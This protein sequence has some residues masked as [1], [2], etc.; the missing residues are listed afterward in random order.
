MPHY[1]HTEQV[2]AAPADIF[3]ILEDTDRTPEW[4]KRC[5]KIDRLEDG[6]TREGLPLRYHYQD[7]KRTGEMA[8]TVSAF[9]PG[10]HMTMSFTDKITDVSVDFVT[11]DGPTPG[12]TTLTHTIDIKTKG[13]GKMFTPMINKAL[14][15][16]TLSAMANLKALAES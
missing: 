5:T 12:T 2:N 4:L 11:A 9:E 8:G 13:I 14:P 10:R 6:P 3:A 15:K 7:G 16:Q 1:T